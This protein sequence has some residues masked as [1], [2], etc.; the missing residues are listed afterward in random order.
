MKKNPV[1]TRY[2]DLST[3]PSNS[4]WRMI[5]ASAEIDQRLLTGDV[6]FVSNVK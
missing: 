5:Q 6:I 2:R 1:P 4:K 3:I